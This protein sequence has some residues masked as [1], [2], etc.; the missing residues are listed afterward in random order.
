MIFT[1]MM[2]SRCLMFVT[3]MP[4]R[5]DTQCQLLGPTFTV[6]LPPHLSRPPA[7]GKV[8]MLLLGLSRI[9]PIPVTVPHLLMWHAKHLLEDPAREVQ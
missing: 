8:G 4:R 5:R 7:V 1:E 3:N 6:S 2:P 9:Y